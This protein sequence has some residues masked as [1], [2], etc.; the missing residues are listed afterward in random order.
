MKILAIGA[1]PDDIALC[2]SG[3]LK[4]F[5]NQG[6]EIFICTATNGCYGSTE[7][8]PF[9]LSSV[10][11]DEDKAV[12]KII[13]ADYYNLQI[14][15]QFVNS[16]VVEQVNKMVNVIRKVE[17]DLII[18]HAPNDYHRDHQET[19]KL[20]FRSSCA[21][22]LHFW[23]GVGKEVPMCPIYLMDGFALKNF[24][25]T[26]YVDISDVIEI[27][28]SLMPLYASQYDWMRIHDGLDLCEYV[29]DCAKVRGYQC[30]VK[31][32]EGFRPDEN[33]G[34]MTTK[35]LLP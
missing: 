16:G 11:V 10:R 34:R 17:P 31:Y 12:A 9:K 13:G 32:A 8:E 4:K 2:C 33:Y 1:H 28:K 18:T 15:D 30:G 14:P 5:K 7:I 24:E 3:T 21:A 6:N 35:R 23:D 20:V 26:E 22:S 27:K 19:Y 25:P 29:E